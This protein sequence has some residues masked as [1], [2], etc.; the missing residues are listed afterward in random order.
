MTKEILLRV[1]D[2]L[3]DIIQEHKDISGVSKTNFIYNAIYWYM[4]SK[5]MISFDYLRCTKKEEEKKKK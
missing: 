2:E 1:P 4:V 5:G 3:H